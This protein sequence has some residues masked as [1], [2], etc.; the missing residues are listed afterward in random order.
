MIES[1]KLRIDHSAP[2]NPSLELLRW[3]EQS[4]QQ[5]LQPLLKAKKT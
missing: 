2:C 3:N 5:P 1:N 4:N